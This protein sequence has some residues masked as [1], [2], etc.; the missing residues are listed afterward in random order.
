M[1]TSRK[2]DIGDMKKLIIG[3]L[4]SASYLVGQQVNVNTISITAPPPTGVSN[5]FISQ[6]GTRGQSTRCYFVVSVYAVGMVAP[7]GPICTTTSNATLTGG[8]Y[9]TVTWQTNNP[10]VTGFWV[11]RANSNVFPGTGTTAVNT[12]VLASTVRTLNDQ[13]NTLHSFTFSAAPTAQNLIGIDN[14]DYPMG[15][16]RVTT[17][18]GVVL[19]EF[20]NHIMSVEGNI[21]LAQINAG[22]MILPP[23]TAGG[24][25]V[26]KVV[27]F[28]Y[29]A[30]G[31]AFGGCTSVDLLDTSLAGVHV[32]DT[33]VADLTQNTVINAT[34][35]NLVFTK[36]A[37]QGGVTD[38]AGLKM[39]KTGSD[40]STATSLNYNIHYKIN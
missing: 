9:N 17:A 22:I 39:Y 32:V 19:D 38:G 28:E 10:A 31:G 29:Q 35:A 25:R 2:R 26:L 24:T 7:Q 14:R 15:V 27:G 11:I 30:I 6:T 18:A 21:T 3:L 1:L 16:A 20:N 40:C 34:A 13:S 12:T 5:Q 36:Y 23:V 8:N 33:P 4:L 37:W